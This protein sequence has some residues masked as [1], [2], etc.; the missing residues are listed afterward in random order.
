MRLY[1]NVT[2][3]ESINVAKFN[4]DYHDEN[5]TSGLFLQDF[6][7]EDIHGLRPPE[8]YEQYESFVTRTG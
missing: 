6:N 5:D 7:K 4:Q 1:N 2:F 3:T 8:I